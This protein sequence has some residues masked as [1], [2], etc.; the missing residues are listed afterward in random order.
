MI[1]MFATFFFIPVGES[2]CRE[3]YWSE[4]LFA[5]SGKK[6]CLMVSEMIQENVDLFDLQSKIFVNYCNA[7]L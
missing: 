3:S 2:E 5:H 6:I 4:H 7:I 1:F